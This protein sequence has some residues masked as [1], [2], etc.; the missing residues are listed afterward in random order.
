MTIH[1]TAFLPILVVAIVCL[2]APAGHATALDDWYLS[3]GTGF[4]YAD[5]IDLDSGAQM[6]FDRGTVQFAAAVG[7]RIQDHWR[8]EAEYSKQ[9]VTPEILYSSAAGIEV[10]SDAGDAVTAT[11]LMLNAIRDLRPGQAW[12]PYVGAGIGMSRVDLRFSELAI[13]APF[14]QRPRRDIVDDDDTTLALQLIAGFTVPL[15]RRLELAADVRYW[16]APD[17]ELEEVSG[18]KLSTDHSVRSAWLRLRYHGPRAGVFDGPAPRQA[19]QRGWYLA[20]TFGG[21][22]AQDED[23]EDRLI[24]I[25]AFDLGSVT[26]LAVGRYLGQRWRV[27]LEASY[28]RNAVEVL[29]FSPEIGEDAASGR[30]ES[31]GLMANVVYQFAPGSSIRPFVGLGA[32]MLRSKYDIETR[33]FCS[34]FICGPDEQR[35]R[36]VDDSGS[37]RAAQLLIGADA[38]ITDRLLFSAAYRQ[39]ITD[40]T[41]LQQPDG[42]PLNIDRRYVSG[43]SVGVRYTLHR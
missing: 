30:A 17:V 24:V 5:S 8:L 36:L 39:L 3:A 9:E 31:Y 18:A 22:F 28:W 34:N 40:T 19:P 14:L 7:R 1:R 35:S 43:I 16:H 21:T 23:I 42:A 2:Y 29:E 33:G 20:G 15:T 41:D 38:A 27:E 4:V 12:R 11:S 10:D 26:S 6:D 13:D 32:G 37:A 25:D